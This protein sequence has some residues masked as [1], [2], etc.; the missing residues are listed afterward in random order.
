MSHQLAQCVWVVAVACGPI[1]VVDD[2]P[3]A[4]VVAT[5]VA[6]S[7]CARAEPYAQAGLRQDVAYLA[8][9]ERAGRVPGT[10]GDLAA[11]EFLAAR[12]ACLGLVDIGAQ[13]G[14]HQPFV[15]DE[16]NATGNVIGIVPGSD[17]SL[18]ADL[19]IV[20]A[21]IDHLG[22]GKLGAN[23]DASGVAALLAAAA[24]CKTQAT[25]PRRTLVFAVFGAEESGFEG[26]AY[27]MAHPPAGMATARMVYNL[28]LDMVG[29][30]A[31]AHTVEALGTFAGTPGRAAVVAYA[32]A[33]PELDVT[34]GNDSD[35][36]D[37]A[38]FC[39]RGIPYVFLWTEDQACYHKACDTADRLDYAGLAQLA[40]LT[41]A[42]AWDLANTVADLRA[43]V[44][45]G[46]AVCLAAEAKRRRE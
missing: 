13:A 19:V 23:D 32:T 3:P 45:P 16:D 28:N 44:R 15:D 17:P 9:P 33:H 8:A 41:G 21:H 39:S 43:A 18:A 26:S 10:A 2:A 5:A 36:S 40:G 4:A 46:R 42:I 31:Q 22:D 14:Y 7:V 38:T 35:Q 11:R 1:Q 34:L 24:A 20:S 29:S 27:F 30:Y 37:H 12:F 6:A 25:P